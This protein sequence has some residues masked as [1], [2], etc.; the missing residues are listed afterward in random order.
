MIGGWSQAVRRESAGSDARFEFPV[1]PLG[2][3]RLVGVA[4]VGFGL[5]FVWMPAHTAWEFIR[6]WHQNGLDVGNVIF[7]LFAFV[8]VVAGCLPMAIGL[9]I[10]FGRCRVEWKDGQLR[11]T[12]ILGPLRWTRRLPRQPVCTLEVSAATTSGSGNAVPR[13][14]EGFSGL[15]VVFEDCSKKMVVLGYPKD[16]LLAVAEELKDYVGGSAFSVASPQVKVVEK[17]P[18]NENDADVPEQ[19][20]GSQVQVEEHTA[21]VRLAVPPAGVSRGSKGLFLFALVW[22]AFMAVFTVVMVL[23]GT[24]K[25]SPLSVP[26]L[27]LLGFWAIGLG[28]L[29]SAINMGRRTATLT[30][31][32]GRLRVE[33]VGPFGAKQLEW[34]RGEVAAIRADASGLEVNHRPVIELQIHTVAGK[35]VGLLAGRKEEEL[36]WLATRLRRALDVPARKSEA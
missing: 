36:R 30:V 29:A 26:I 11:A 35:K 4:L 22:C 5:L 15:A 21:G 10:L 19:P 2:W 33:T 17:S 31:E 13:Q 24:K 28:M 23:P 34:S 7:S 12:E 1:R 3:G 8:F 27:F 6:K 14:L 32:A 20:A 9:L 16:W 18:V 25:E